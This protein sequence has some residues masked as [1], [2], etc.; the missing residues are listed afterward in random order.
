MPAVIA[1]APPGVLEK[2]G[3]VVPGADTLVRF[4]YRTG[5]ASAVSAALV[6]LALFQ[7]AL[8]TSTVP[9]PLAIVVAVLLLIPAAA[10]GLVGWTLADLVRLPGQLRQA[11]LAAAGGATGAVA[12]KGSRIVR[13]FRAIWAARGLALGSKDAWL[14]AIAAARFIRL[15]SLPFVLALVGLFALNGVVIAAGL[16]ALVFLIL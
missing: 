2:L 7:G 3:R 16:V 15:A 6:W 13:V 4:A 10:A 5:L 11:A 1:E 9:W 12:A 8:G 14:R